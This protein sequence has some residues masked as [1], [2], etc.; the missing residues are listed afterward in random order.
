MD[1]LLAH[2]GLS[3]NLAGAKGE[4]VARGCRGGR[5]RRSSLS[6]E[7]WGSRRR[8]WTACPLEQV[9]HRIHHRRVGTASELVAV[10]VKEFQLGSIDD[11][12]IAFGMGG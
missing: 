11:V 12:D 9:V 2:C 6:A 8:G 3:A 10:A 7:L 4:G 5:T 1:P